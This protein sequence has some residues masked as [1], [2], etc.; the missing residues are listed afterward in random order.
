MNDFAY[1]A[2]LRAEL[3]NGGI[4]AMLYDLL[5]LDLGNWHPMQIYQTQALLEQKQH[6]LRGLDAWIEAMLQEGALPKPLS[7]KYPNRCLSENLEGAAKQFDRFTNKSRVAR[8]LQ[9]LLAVEPFNNQDLRGWIFPPLADARK[10]WERRNG[11]HWIWHREVKEWSWHIW[12][13]M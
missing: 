4:E 13:G 7:S 9:D 10:L 6:S 3:D 5:A 11:G 8:K 12:S 1:F 2:A